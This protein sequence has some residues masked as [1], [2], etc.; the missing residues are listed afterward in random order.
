M[1]DVGHGS[2]AFGCRSL[3]RVRLCGAG[4]GPG[5][6]RG[7]GQMRSRRE[8][9]RLMVRVRQPHRRMRTLR[10]PARAGHAR[11]RGRP[12]CPNCLITDPANT[13]VCVSSGERR[14]V[15][16]RTQDGPICPNCCALPVLVCSKGG[17]TAPCT[18]SRLTELP[19]CGGCDRRQAHC[20]ACGRLRG[21][22][23]GTADALM[24]WERGGRQQRVTKA[25]ASPN[26]LSSA[27]PEPPWRTPPVG[28]SNP[29]TRPR[30]RHP[31]CCCPP[32]YRP[33][34][35]SAR[36]RC[37]RGRRAGSSRPSCAA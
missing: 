14:R 32:A 29:G 31:C 22:H 30:R 2:S 26:D 34:C 24:R 5:L 7:G 12:L 18:L 11:R 6:G 10:S 23:S 33:C 9:R 17:P 3:C 15:R 25:I 8:I 28:S 37:R 4:P 13:E 20:T 27:W 19:R 16:T 21:I 36:G 35:R 1:C